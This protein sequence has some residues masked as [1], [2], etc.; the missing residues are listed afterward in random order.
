MTDE[1][2]ATAE[3][4][5]ERDAQ[6]KGAQAQ[7]AEATAATAEKPEPDQES[8]EARPSTDW[9]RAY[10]GVQTKINRLNDALTSERRGRQ[11]LLHQ[12]SELAEAIQYLKESQ[13][14]ILASTVGEDKAKELDQRMRSASAGN[15]QTQA[16]DAA[17]TFT[18]QQAALFLDTLDAMG[19]AKND[20][21]IDWAKDAATTEEWYDRVRASVRARVSKEREQY[22]QA[23]E[24][25]KSGLDKEAK[26][27]ADELT[28]KQLKDAGMDKI[29]TG[30]GAPAQS[31]GQKIAQMD[32]TSPEFHKILQQAKAG[33]LRI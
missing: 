7:A 13:G 19:I 21:E 5:D 10:K 9:E 2:T 29:D 15:R 33:K 27:K 4:P 32:P 26:V 25:A 20:P 22:V 18:K 28:K 14:E 11:D 6:A 23:V 1:T 8:K 31:L 16:L 24:K 30:K 3:K 12:N 17:M